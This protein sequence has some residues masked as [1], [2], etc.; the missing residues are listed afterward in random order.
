[1]LKRTVDVST[2]QE[3]LQYTVIAASLRDLEFPVRQFQYCT[4]FETV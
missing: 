2:P 1:M 4:H 3:R